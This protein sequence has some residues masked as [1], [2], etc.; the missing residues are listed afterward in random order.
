[1]FGVP[2]GTLADRFSRKSLVV[3]S[4][5]MKSAASVTWFLWQD[6]CGYALGFIIWGVGS[7]FHSGAF[8]ALLFETLKSSQRASDFGYHYSKVRT[9]GTVYI[10]LGEA[11]DG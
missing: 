10:L 6:F 2:S 4:G 5:V 9:L 3:L 11:S 1:M 8:E 7:P